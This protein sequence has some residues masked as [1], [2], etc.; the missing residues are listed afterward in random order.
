[1]TWFRARFK[2]GSLDFTFQAQ[3]FPQAAIKLHRQGVDFDCLKALE[4]VSR[5]E[6]VRIGRIQALKLPTMREKA[7]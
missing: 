4:E 5:R 3:D 6:Q 2:E 1:M 7:L